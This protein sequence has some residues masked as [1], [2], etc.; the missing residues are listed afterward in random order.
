MLL[1]WGTIYLVASTW[2]STVQYID[3][4]ICTIINFAYD[5]NLPLFDN[6]V[7]H[8][9]LDVSIILGIVNMEIVEQKNWLSH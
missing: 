6:V 2:Q 7:Y 9:I 4:F 1:T 5:S 3:I 8:I